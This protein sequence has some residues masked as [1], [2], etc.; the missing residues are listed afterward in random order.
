MLAGQPSIC[1]VLAY[2]SLREIEIKNIIHI[3]E[4]V[5]YGTSVENIRNCF[6]GV[7]SQYDVVES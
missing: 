4:G 7:G 5:R 3:V 6:F 2:L 1:V